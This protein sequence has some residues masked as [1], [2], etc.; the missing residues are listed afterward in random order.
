MADVEISSADIPGFSVATNNGITVA[1]D[2]TL[3]KELKE[4]GLAREF[5]NRIQ[6]LR[7]DNGFEVTDK[8]KIWVEKNDL[9]TA[10]IKNNFI[11][12]CEET[13]AVQLNYERTVISNAV[14][15]ELI[16]GISINVSL[17]KN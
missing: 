12:I 15:V 6:H 5:V 10:S 13:L 1:L 7:K 11:Y 14:A 9:I 16:D 2:I 4:E 17:V 3:S 8:V